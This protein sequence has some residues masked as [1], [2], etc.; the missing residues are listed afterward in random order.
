MT[1]RDLGRNMHLAEGK[2][3]SAAKMSNVMIARAS[4]AL[5]CKQEKR[6][7][8]GEHWWQTD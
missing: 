7:R 3:A 8:D 1:W 2:A 5:A 4:F 6:V